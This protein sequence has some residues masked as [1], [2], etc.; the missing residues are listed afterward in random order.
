[1]LPWTLLYC[2]KNVAGIHVCIRGRGQG[3]LDPPPPSPE[4]RRN[5]V[6]PCNAGPDP[7]K[8]HKVAN[9]AFNAGPLSVCQQIQWLF[10]SGP[11]SSP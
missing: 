6:F 8:N 7:L 9:L 10:A 3:S 4:N 5:I 1:M 2:T 11:M